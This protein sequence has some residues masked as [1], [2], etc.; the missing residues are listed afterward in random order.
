MAKLFP[1]LVF[2]RGPQK[3][4]RVPLAKTM[5]VVGRDRGCEIEIQDEYASRQHARI[6]VEGN[7]VRLVNTSPNG[8]KV[9]G[10]LVDQAVLSPGDV[11]GF[12]LECEARLEAAESPAG[13]GKPGGPPPP[14]P[15]RG[16]QARGTEEKSGEKGEESQAKKKLKKP[17]AIVW[18]GVYLLVLAGLVVFFQQLRKEDA[19]PRVNLPYL[20]S[21]DIAAMLDA[22]LKD[23]SGRPF[24]PNDR[25]AGVELHDAI[26]S[27]ETWKTGTS[28]SS[29][30]YRTFQGFKRALAYRG[31]ESNDFGTE[32]YRPPGGQPILVQRIY[33]EVREEL[34]DRIGATYRAAFQEERT[35]H[36]RL[37]RENFNMVVG[38]ID[39]DKDPIRKNVHA[40]L[41]YVN[42]QER[43]EKDRKGKW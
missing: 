3:G 33:E 1:E 13:A 32:I 29:D 5:N 25:L 18:V 21:K 2:T 36:W 17:P 7:R 31:A 34:I 14:L 43:R 40:H 22:P 38:M 8:T 6:I 12:G 16:E 35:G 9:N 27:Y 10:K 39:D 24:A 28:K 30:L 37:A 41:A 26:K 42:E 4:L 11:L 20:T 23:E 15:A 19:G